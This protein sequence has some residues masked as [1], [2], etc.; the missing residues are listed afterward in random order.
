VMV[1]VNGRFPRQIGAVTGIL[2]TVAVGGT[3]VLQPVVGRVAET[4]GLQVGV[5]LVAASML[6]SSVLLLAVW[7]RDRG[8]ASPAH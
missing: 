7:L 3:F 1:Y 4:A 2:S 5:L 6:V 8:A